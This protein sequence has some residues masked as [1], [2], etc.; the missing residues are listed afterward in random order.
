MDSLQHLE[1]FKH[2]IVSQKWLANGDLMLPC[3]VTY[4][5]QGNVINEKVTAFIVFSGYESGK[6]TLHEG[7]EIVP[8]NVHIEFTPHFQEYVFLSDGRLQ[9]TG[10]SSRLGSYQVTLSPI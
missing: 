1:L 6:I 8:E 10:S 3:D 2:S 7:I 5:Y 4:R 9:I